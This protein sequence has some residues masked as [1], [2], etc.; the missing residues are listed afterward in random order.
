VHFFFDDHDFDSGAI[1][2][3][4]FDESEVQLIKT[5]TAAMDRVIGSGRSSISD[6]DA[7]GH[8]AWSQVEDAARE[9]LGVLQTRGVPR[10]EEG[11][12]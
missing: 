7:L 11:S 12:P 5:L 6:R 9:A 2:S 10:F 1:G 3:V 4:L 8:P